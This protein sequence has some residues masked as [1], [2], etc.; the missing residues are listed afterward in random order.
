M[1]QWNSCANSLRNLLSFFRF[2][3][4]QK[5][6]FIFTNETML[7]PTSLRLN[8]TYVTVYNTWMKL[9]I[10]EAIPYFAI[11]TLNIAIVR[12]IL[13]SSSFRAM[14]SANVNEAEIFQVPYLGA[15]E[16]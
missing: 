2:F 3:E 10:I 1:K 5:G 7:E 6:Y 13:K 14:A 15:L 8:K 9:I 16:N 4:L 12:A 11:L